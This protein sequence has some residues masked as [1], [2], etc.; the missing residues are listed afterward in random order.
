MDHE[1]L[2]QDAIRMSGMELDED[3]DPV[4]HPDE[5][6]WQGISP[7]I[8]LDVNGAPE[9]S[10]PTED[11][12]WEG[13]FV[14]CEWKPVSS[15]SGR[16]RHGGSWISRGGTSRSGRRL[17]P[18]D[19]EPYDYA[20]SGDLGYSH[21]IAHRM[22][23]PI[24]A[25]IY[26]ALLGPDAGDV[27]AILGDPAAE[28][29]EESLLSQIRELAPEEAEGDLDGWL[30]E[31]IDEISDELKVEIH[32]MTVLSEREV[33][34]AILE[35]TRLTHFD[36]TLEEIREAIQIRGVPNGFALEPG[37]SADLLYARTGW[38]G[39]PDAPKTDEEILEILKKQFPERYADVESVSCSDEYS[40]DGWFGVHVRR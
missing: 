36:R 24:L 3:G 29:S 34:E 5:I 32:R 23:R 37:P 26:S 15:N 17:E 35:D 39:D 31:E 22:R 6:A 30:E 25:A 10:W 27:L 21:E 28:M 12:R 19:L 13:G 16:I 11:P 20:E 33:R 14:N 38:Q 40:E 1:K 18:G 7:R 4:V 8:A 2:A 9:I